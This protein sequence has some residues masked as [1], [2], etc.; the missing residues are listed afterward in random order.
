MVG[1]SFNALAASVQEADGRLLAH[2][3]RLH[4][5]A[6]EVDLLRGA[7]AERKL[8]EAAASEA[9]GTASSLALQRFGS[10]VLD[11]YVLRYLGILASFTAMLPAVMHGVA[12]GGGAADDPTEYAAAG[13]LP[14]VIRPYH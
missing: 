8:M 6:E 12:P 1:P 3:A 14:S 11:N 13:T 9:Q 7:P 2:H 5:Y 4:E 10:D